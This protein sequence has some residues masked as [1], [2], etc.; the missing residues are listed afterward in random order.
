[1]GG[2]GG[3][4]N[5]K[6]IEERDEERGRLLREEVAHLFDS[7][8]RLLLGNGCELVR[9]GVCIY[10]YVC[11]CVCVHICVCVCVCTYMCVHVCVRSW[12]LSGNK[13][14]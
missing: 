7:R 14:E 9:V 3:G 6:G 12:L 8:N 4:N 5:A 11:A 13:C 10:I 2:G 1:M